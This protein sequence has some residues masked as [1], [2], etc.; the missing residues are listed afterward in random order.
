MIR[1]KAIIFYST[2]FLVFC[3]SG[4]IST[5]ILLRDGDIFRQGIVI[6]FLI[7]PLIFVYGLKV[8]KVLLAFCLLAFIVLLSGLYNKSSISDIVYF[9]RQLIFPIF[10]YTLINW[11]INSENITRIIKLCTV[12]A[13]VQ[14]PLVV[15]EQLY[16]YKLPA[17]L[18]TRIY[19]LDIGIGTFNIGGDAA[20]GF[21]IV[22]LVIFLLFDAKHNY[23]IQKKW[24]ILP[25]LTLTIVVANAELLKLVVVFIWLVYFI[26]R[27][28]I[29]R[30]VYVVLL[31][32]IVLGILS[33]FHR[34]DETWTGF[35]RAL[36][37]ATQTSSND[38]ERFLSGGYARGAAIAYY[39]NR[40]LSLLGDGPSRY[41]DPIN[42]IKIWG[43]NGH[44]FT[45]YSEIGL[46]GLIA[47]V[48]IFFLINFPIYQGKIHVTWV[49]TLSF[50]SIVM[51]SFTTPI[52]DNIA[53]I[54]M[55]CIMAKIS[56]IQDT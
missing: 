26:V 49:N 36:S 33:V 41:Y 29:K 50:L 56:M 11:Y 43:N 52:M 19:S 42:R 7:L 15:L 54:L 44:F 3:L 23:I 13:L 25:W 12:I 31:L 53:V 24:I 2:F 16:Y 18:Q 40:G 4:L 17:S 10:V 27:F 20:M 35:T 8:D 48:V 9:S 22:L 28:K 1:P 37:S 51:L 39:V 21:F 32:S 38:Q 47:S 6:S 34:L 55:Y 14:L 5:L 46:L 45:F 30:V